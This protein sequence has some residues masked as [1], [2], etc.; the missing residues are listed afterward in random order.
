MGDFRYT[1]DTDITG[2]CA[3]PV[4]P[5]CGHIATAHLA[6]PKRNS[7]SDTPGDGSSAQHL[8]GSRQSHEEK[9]RYVTAVTRLT[10]SR[11]QCGCRGPAKVAADLED[12]AIT[13]TVPADVA[14]DIAKSKLFRTTFAVLLPASR[15]ASTTTRRRSTL[16]VGPETLASML[17]ALINHGT[18]YASCIKNGIGSVE[19]GCTQYDGSL[20]HSKPD[21]YGTMRYADGSQYTY[22]FAETMCSIT[23]NQ[24]PQENTELSCVAE[25]S[26][27]TASVTGWALTLA[28][29]GTSTTASGSWDPSTATASLQGLRPRTKA[30]GQMA[31]RMASAC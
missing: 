21:G 24:K 14:D 2:K 25:G 1:F 30:T 26:G 29:V 28:R 20:K 5:V 6:R 27:R 4:C 17:D 3:A 8:K 13:V 16:T 31:S 7:T 23:V 9:T 22:V 12:A 10:P 15:R 18:A 19:S 11:T